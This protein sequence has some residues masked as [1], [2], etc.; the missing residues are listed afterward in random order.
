MRDREPGA[1]AIITQ[2]ERGNR[3]KSYAKKQNRHYLN[4]YNTCSGLSGKGDS[5]SLCLDDSV[6]G[7][8][9]MI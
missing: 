9:L 7:V 5:Q 2:K 1:Q 8:K 4:N 6:D 3:F